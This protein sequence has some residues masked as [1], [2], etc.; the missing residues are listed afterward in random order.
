MLPVEQALFHGGVI[1]ID[2][3]GGLLVVAYALAGVVALVRT[4]SLA[5]ARLLV[6][7]GA[8]FGLSFKTAG[9]LMKT[10]ELHTWDQI[11]MF[12]AVF[13]LRVVL[14]QLFVWEKSRVQL[15]IP[16]SL[17]HIESPALEHEPDK[18]PG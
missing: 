13:T 3:I 15:P 6:A 9:T 5:Q 12:G 18:E 2:L 4:R 14:K 7:E 17:C 16:G 11:M 1:L 8:V 10:L